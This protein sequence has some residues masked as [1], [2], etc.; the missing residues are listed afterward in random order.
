[1]IISMNSACLIFPA[2]GIGSS[3]LLHFMKSLTD[4]HLE[5]KIL[6]V[7]S[8]DL[9]SLAEEWFPYVLVDNFR[10]VDDLIGRLDG[11]KQERGIDYSG[12][13]GIDE[14]EQF[15]LSRA[16]AKRYMLAFHR[17]E[18]CRIAS[19]KYL[20]KR[21]FTREKV[22]IGR[23]GLISDPDDPVVADVGFPSVLKLMSGVGS[24]FLFF[25]PDEAHFR[26]NMIRMQAA[27]ERSDKTNL[28][29]VRQVTVDGDG[30]QL[31]PR[32]QFLLDQYIPG[33]EFSCDF[34]VRNGE[35]YVIRIVKKIQGPVFGFFY[36][37]YLPDR[38]DLEREDF[39]LSGWREICVRIAR[40]LAVDRGICMVDFKRD[41][42]SFRILEASI[43]PGLSAFNHLMYRVCGYTALSLAA[44]LAMG[45]EIDVTLPDT[46]GAVV[47]FYKNSLMEPGAYRE[48]IA[49]QGGRFGAETI[50]YYEESEDESTES[51]VDHSGM[52]QG[53]MVFTHI[54]QEALAVLIHELGKQNSIRSGS[55]DRTGFDS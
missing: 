26:E 36:G 1:M 27:A 10:S 6:L 33:N 49:E 25:N 20:Q 31:E 13:L 4:R 37:Y 43:R 12:I 19:N 22:P 50:F 45:E 9:Q 30:M 15:G 42:R 14:E 40:A 3:E 46:P 18:T 28:L 52:L 16:I 29:D 17:E 5:E 23:W 48:Y 38:A 8:S 55:E 44:R 35:P 24:Q 51:D 11:W 39:D 41:G 54:R 53:Y 2:F 7:C 32:R 34:L 47:Y 21:V